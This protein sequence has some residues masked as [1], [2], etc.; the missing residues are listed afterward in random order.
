MLAVRALTLEGAGEGEAFFLRPDF[1]KLTGEAALVA[2]GHAFFSLSLGMGIMITYGAYV[3]RRQSLGSA[4][5]AVGGLF[6][7]LLAI[8]A[9][10]SAVSILEVPVAYVR[11]KFGLSRS[12]AAALTGIACF[13]VGLPS[14]LSAGDALPG[15]RFAGKSFFDWMDFISLNV[16]L[17]VGGLA[18]SVFAGYIWQ[19]AGEEAG[20]S[21][22]WFRV[23]IAALRC[24][25]PIL[26]LLV[27][28]N[29]VGFLPW[30]QKQLW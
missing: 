30:L 11:E 6:F 9:L 8:A 28:L 23:W 22:G 5:L 26:L 16:I 13:L 29:L 10:T 12:K 24:L 3:E 18:V 27:M 15:L 21:A 17:P 2:L 25:A 20:I 7:I 4:A 1:S 19:K 14:A